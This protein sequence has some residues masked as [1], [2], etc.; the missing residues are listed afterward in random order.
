MS[1][2]SI[3]PVATQKV[4]EDKQPNTK[5]VRPGLAGVG[6]SLVSDKYDLGLT[7]KSGGQPTQRA[8]STCNDTCS[9]CRQTDSGCT[10]TQTANSTC[11]GC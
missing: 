10:Q 3:N 6:S 11:S 2:K 4:S 9:G 8:T 5:T 7:I 1:V